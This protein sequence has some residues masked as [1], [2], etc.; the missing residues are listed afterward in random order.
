VGECSGHAGCAPSVLD[1][2]FL[3]TVDD[4]SGNYNT[5]VLGGGACID[6]GGVRFSEGDDFAHATMGAAYASGGEFAIS[7]WLLKA[8]ANV[9]D[10]HS[11]T[12]ELYSNVIHPDAQD[13]WHHTGVILS[14]VRA[15]W[16]DAWMLDVELGVRKHR[17]VLNIL[18]DSVPIWTHL[19]IVVTPTS[20]E[21]YEN[22]RRIQLGK[23]FEWECVFRQTIPNFR[24]VLDWVRYNDDA[25]RDIEDFSILDELEDFRQSDG[26]LTM[27]LVWPRVA[28]ANGNTWR[29]LN[30][31]VKAAVNGVEG[32]EPLDI[33][34]T[35]QNWGGLEHTAR[36]SL[37]S[38]SI[39]KIGYWFYAVGVEEDDWAN[40]NG[41]HGTI[42]GASGDAQSVSRTELWIQREV[43]HTGGS[44]RAHPDSGFVAMASVLSKSA[45]I[46]GNFRG[47]VAM[48]QVYASALST[49]EAHCVYE[50]GR[51]LVQ[52]GQMGQHVP[53][54]CRAIVATRCT[55]NV[56]ASKIANTAPDAASSIIVDDGSCS[57]PETE[58][59]GESGV[60]EITDGWQLISLMQSYTKPVV[61][62]GVLTRQS[63]A[64]AVIRI[65]T[66]EM[67][68][69]GV[70][71]FEVRAE[72][73]SCH[74]ARPPPTAERASYLVVE[75]GLSTEGWQASVIRAHDREWRRVSL[76]RRFDSDSSGSFSAP[77]VISHVQNYDSRTEFVTTRHHLAPVPLLSA[78]ADHPYQ[79]FFV[80]VQS[81]GVWCPDGHYYTEY[82][83]NLQLGGT[84]VATVCELTAPDWHWHTC[85][86]GMPPTMDLHGSVFFSARWT[87]RV[88]IYK[89]GIQL[90]FSST[91]SSG[92]RIMLDGTTVLDSWQECCST[93]TSDL[94]TIGEGY[95]ILTYEYRSAANRDTIPTNSYAGL[96]LSTDSDALAFEST[97][98]TGE[99]PNVLESNASPLY[100]DIG[101]LACMP[102]FST[103]N[104]QQLQ[105]GFAQ[106]TSD[107]TTTIGFA[108]HF[109]IFVPMIFASL[110]STGT[111]NGQLRLLTASKGQIS[112]ATEYNTCNYIV[113]AA[114]SMISW[115][116]VASP[117]DAVNSAVSQQ[118]TNAS[119]VAALL[120]IGESLS[121]P[122]YLQWHNNSDPC[123]DRWAGIEC[124]TFRGTPRV[125]VLDVRSP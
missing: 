71:S 73:K 9:V 63:T 1:V 124:R 22:S 76:L 105:A 114:D 17:F 65:R 98:Y 82:F 103:I 83:D 41:I 112:L 93:F 77:V 91:A 21:V 45:T 80:Q 116:I 5:I 4:N 55:S 62:A 44:V 23:S 31:P 58:L 13:T 60:I 56:G 40:S 110:V 20:I 122:D 59:G 12:E 43:V 69:N 90:S 86:S 37:L 107:L 18:R 61:F 119:D 97:N 111:L 120:Q 118:P 75:A 28:G 104:S 35:A 34:F 123:R 94:V 46:G 106:T 53:S 51:R 24:P 87:S 8:P 115:I 79:A 54:E 19:S 113:D 85:C 26:K 57:F 14:V 67:G 108:D 81:E 3:N 99:L 74:F 50:G 64:Q 72:Q 7:L 89:N 92:S 70:W 102:G 10:E 25:N 84:P 95:H 78:I 33:Y 32:Y 39:D 47:S 121:L 29:Q 109:T 48:L 68:S 36:S 101:W 100:A 2:G 125:V 96:T 42:P 38:G 49:S 16:L 27:R 30:N 6:D 11:S 88:G 117:V 66:V 15:D 52:S